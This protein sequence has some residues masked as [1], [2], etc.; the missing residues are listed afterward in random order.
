MELFKY[1]NSF[2]L[3]GSKTG[4]KPGLSRIKRLLQY[5]GNPHQNLNIIHLAGTNGKGSTAAILE[6]SYREAGYKTALYSS[7]HFFHF[8]E[9]IKVNGR[10]CSTYDLEEIV[11]EIKIAS[12]KMIKENYS[13]PSFFEIV[14]AAAFKYFKQQ[15]AEIVILETGLGG[16]LDATNIVE[17]PLMSIITNIS[18]EHSSLLGD[19]TAEIAAEKAG[20]IKADSKVLTAV[21]QKKALKVIREKAAAVNAKFINLKDEYSLIK[22]NGSLNQNSII[23]KKKGVKEEY[24]LSLLG[25]HQAFNAALALR[26]IEELDSDYPVA[27]AEIKKALKNV[28]WPGRMQKVS[29]KPNIIL[30]AAHNPAAFKELAAN[31]YQSRS[32]FDNLHLVFS[33]LADKDLDSVLK[34]FIK[35]DLSPQFYLAENKSFRTIEINDLEQK[36][37]EFSFQYQSYEDLTAASQAALKNAKTNDLIIAAGSFNTVFEAGIEFMIQTSGGEDNE[38]E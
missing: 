22:S 12:E 13:K 16:R 20:I 24:S 30:D 8:N 38:K 36:I 25:A 29:Q 28:F 10:A 18:L 27:K 3:F 37:G 21:N 11:K 31:I 6:R 33:I 1:I 35:L 5:L 17:K 26:T 9:R 2:P 7:P 15:Q 32:E 23:L 14:T 34:E 4:Y 19:T